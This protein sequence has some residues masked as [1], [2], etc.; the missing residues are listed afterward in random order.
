MI[1]KWLLF[2]S[3]ALMNL[4]DATFVSKALVRWSYELWVSFKTTMYNIIPLCLE[5]FQSKEWT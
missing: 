4:R 5:I 2:Y 3:Y 1:D